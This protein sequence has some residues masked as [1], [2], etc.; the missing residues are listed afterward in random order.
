MTTSF[1]RYVHICA[2]FY[3]C[4]PCMFVCMCTYARWHRQ[5]VFQMHTHICTCARVLTHACMHACMCV[6][7]AYAGM[8]AC[9]H[10]CMY[11][12]MHE[13]MYACMYVCMYAH[14]FTH[15][16]I[17]CT[18]L[19]VHS[20]YIIYFQMFLCSTILSIYAVHTCIHK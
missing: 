13:C 20:I 5:S 17:T 1:S 14:T 19:H 10:V 16:H 11:V 8:Y 18:H 12:C 2:S 3:E 9:M 4:I 15:T 6:K 7:C